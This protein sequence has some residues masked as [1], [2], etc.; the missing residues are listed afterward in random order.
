[1]LHGFHTIKT[2]NN[3]KKFTV[4]TK[5]QPFFLHKHFLH[6][7]KSLVNF[8]SLGKLILAILACFLIVFKEETLKILTLAFL[9]FFFFPNTHGFTL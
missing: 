7:C 2:N 3:T 4:L 8:Q 9:C 6:H 1:M 5:I